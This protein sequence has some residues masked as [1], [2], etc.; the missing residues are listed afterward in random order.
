MTGTKT[1]GLTPLNGMHHSR[2]IHKK[3][4]VLHQAQDLYA[5]FLDPTKQ[6]RLRAWF[7]V[8]FADFELQHRCTRRQG[9]PARRM[10]GAGGTGR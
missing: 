10:N 5:L 7:R 2:S 9:D 1:K 8:R 4:A 6:L 3:R